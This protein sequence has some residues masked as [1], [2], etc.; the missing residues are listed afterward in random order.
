MNNYEIAKSWFRLALADWRVIEKLD[1]NENRGAIVYHLQQ[2]VE[3]LCK[4]ILALLGFEPPRTHT[5]STE[6]DR[7]LADIYVG[8]LRLDVDN[9]TLRDLERL[10]SLAKTF[11]DEGTRPRYGV[12]H[13]NRIILPDEYYSTDTVRLFIDDAKIVAE[14][15]FRILRRLNFCKEAEDICGELIGISG[16][17]A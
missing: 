7:I 16:R 12:R 6:I 2:F 10:S 4:G 14:I 5:P 8:S 1:I 9:E 13:A 3:K 15:T 11:E 17:D